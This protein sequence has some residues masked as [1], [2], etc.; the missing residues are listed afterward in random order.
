[1]KAKK[2]VVSSLAGVLCLAL[3]SIAS[4][5]TWSGWGTITQLYSWG[6]G[7]HVGLSTSIPNP[8][9]CSFSAYAFLDS[10]LPQAE[11]DEIDRTL[12]SALLSGRQVQLLV[13]SAAGACDGGYPQF[14]AVT[15]K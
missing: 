12:L 4:A 14:Y 8:A 11:K 9:G 15:V 3:T 6:V 2:L 13:N 1:M 5:S 7:Y 10:S